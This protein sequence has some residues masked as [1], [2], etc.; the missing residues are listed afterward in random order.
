MAA[1][2]KSWAEKYQIRTAPE[3]KVLEKDFAGMPAG[4]QMLIATPAIIEAYIRQIP[5]GH[6]VSLQTL[7]QD[8]ALL[9]QAE[10]TCPVTTGIFLRIVAQYQYER[11][12]QGETRMAIAPFWRIDAPLFEHKLSCG[13]AWVEQ[14]RMADLMAP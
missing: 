11:W 6:L 10:Q 3:V 1:K 4:T 9:H 5:P 7:R 8:L 13:K 14:Q 12:Q 2:P